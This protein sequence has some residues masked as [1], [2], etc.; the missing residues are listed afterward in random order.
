MPSYSGY[1]R[2]A[3]SKDWERLLPFHLVASSQFR[4]YWELLAGVRAMKTIRHTDTLVYYDGVQVFEGRD[5]I[6]GH[7]IGV[8]I[9]SQDDADIYLV[10]GTVPEHL[11]QFRLGTLDLKTLLLEGSRYGW[12]TTQTDD[13][14]IQSL[15]LEVQEGS[16]ERRDFLPDDGFLLNEAISEDDLALREAIQRRNVVFEFSVNPPEAT[17]AHRIRSSTLGNL[18]THVQLVVRYAYCN[19]INMVSRQVRN[20]IDTTDAYLMDVVI[21]AAPG[22]FRIVLEASKPADMFGYGE[23]ARG[24]KLMDSIFEGVQD[25]N[26][27]RETLIEHRGRLTK[28]YIN[29]MK[30]LV[31]NKTGLRY[32]WAEPSLTASRRGR[33]SEALAWKLVDEFSGSDSLGQEPVVFIGEFEKVNRGAG[34]WGLLTDDGNV[35]S[36][37][38]AD[39]GPSLDGLEVG[40]RYRFDCVDEVEFVLATGH[41]KH[42]FF[43]KKIDPM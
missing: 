2:G 23:L 22:S 37:K 26:S 41:E 24:L 29:L 43:L 15:D 7:Y 1:R 39:G 27:A 6:G 21:P 16:L 12:Y 3:Y 14:L 34:D 33:V 10:T 35:K 4:H 9:D 32:S 42:T 18:L 13:D 31:E 38:V 40:K 17:Y 25:Q 20:T 28:S 5:P 30:L 36:G 19:A 8:M 11:R